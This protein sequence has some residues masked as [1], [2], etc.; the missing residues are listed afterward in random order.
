MKT[1]STLTVVTIAAGA[2]ACGRGTDARRSDV[3]PNESTNS[4]NP[5]R[6][7]QLTQTALTGCLQAGD[8]AGSYV[9]RIV[10]DTPE[11]ATR[12]RSS[13]TTGGGAT[14][15]P[16]GTSTT[17]AGGDAVANSP[18]IGGGALPATYRVVPVNANAVDL[19]ANVNAQ[20]SVLGVIE[21]SA[22]AS[23]GGAP[24]RAEGSA[25]QGGSVAA[26]G[27][28]NHGGHGGAVGGAVTADGVHTLRVSTITRV[29]DKCSAAR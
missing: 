29:A 17:G 7:G 8:T 15:A 13:G 24:A 14:P 1:L 3:N 27:Q 20:V 9:L 21:D 2:I 22:T 28:G 10:S 12:A 25:P 19:H 18:T 6:S 26:S 4:G 23:A 11:G 5:Q 16:R